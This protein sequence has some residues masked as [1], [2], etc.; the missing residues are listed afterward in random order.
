MLTSQVRDIR[1]GKH[2]LHVLVGLL[3]L[4]A[5]FLF[6]EEFVVEVG[7]F[8]FE[9]RHAFSVVLTAARHLEARVHL[10]LQL[11]LNN[12]Q[13]LLR[14]LTTFR[15]D[16]ELALRLCTA[17]WRLELITNTIYLRGL[18]HYV[19]SLTSCLRMARFRSNSIRSRRNDDS[20]FAT[21]SN[22]RCNDLEEDDNTLTSLPRR[23][24]VVQLTDTCL[25]FV[26]S[27]NSRFLVVL[28]DVAA[29]QPPPDSA[30][31]SHQNVHVNFFVFL[32][33]NNFFFKLQIL[34]IE[35]WWGPCKNKK[36]NFR[37]H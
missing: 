37:K 5:G 26:A 1:S 32:Q 28:R 33:K 31:T 4:A 27:R 22:S 25:Q 15:F 36:S 20:S 24:M 3:V 7:D 16:V 29:S 6:G 17:M 12:S 34:T 18:K 11:L 14:V 9:L 30:A 19:T 10:H 13:L 21:R 2:L 23:G 8:A 35:L